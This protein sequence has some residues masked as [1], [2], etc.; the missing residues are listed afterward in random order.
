MGFRSP[1]NPGENGWGT[2]QQAEGSKDEQKNEPDERNEDGAGQQTA[3]DEGIFLL[4]VGDLPFSQDHA[5]LDMS[6][7][8]SYQLALRIRRQRIGRVTCLDRSRYP[9]HELAVSR[10]IL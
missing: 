1:W 10:L 4:I 5:G 9:L 7:Y 2:Q 3:G 8:Q 6:M